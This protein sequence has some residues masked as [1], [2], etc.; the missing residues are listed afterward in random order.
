MKNVKLFGG[1]IE[2][3]VPNK[4]IDASSLRDVPDHQEVFLDSASADISIIFEI[5]DYESNVGTDNAGEFFFKDYVEAC[6][7]AEFK[8]NQTTIEPFSDPLQLGFER[9][10]V[11]GVQRASKIGCSAEQDVI[12]CLTIIRLP[13]VKSEVIIIINWPNG[14]YEEALKLQRGLMDGFRVVD[15]TLFT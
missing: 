14:N 9:V 11:S 7:S 1:A 8:I 15:R 2:A 3:V 10:L 4:F 12:V 13:A 6:Q 5:V